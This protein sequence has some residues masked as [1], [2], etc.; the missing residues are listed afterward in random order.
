MTIAHRALSAAFGTS[1]A[2]RRP[3][4]GQ[5]RQEE[6]SKSRRYGVTGNITSSPWEG[7]YLED[8]A[9]AEQAFEERVE[10]NEEQYRFLNGIMYGE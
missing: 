8:D 10:P 4:K 3:K 7:L 2:T 9:P 1:H 6:L 5:A